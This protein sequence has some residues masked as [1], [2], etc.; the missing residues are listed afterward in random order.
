MLTALNNLYF[1]LHAINVKLLLSTMSL[2]ISTDISLPTTVDVITSSSQLMI[3][4]L[5]AIHSN[6]LFS[7]LSGL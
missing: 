1:N 5:P 6:I 7:T 4:H 2:F 3:K